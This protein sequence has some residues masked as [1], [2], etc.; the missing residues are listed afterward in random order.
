MSDNPSTEDSW[1]KVWAFYQG[2][3]ASSGDT[4]FTLTY[5][6]ASAT[7]PAATATDVLTTASALTAYGYTE[8]QADSIPVAINAL[9]ADALALRKVLV[10]VID[11]LVA[12]GA[13]TS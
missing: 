3:L 2:F 12:I 1:E 8:A 6:T 4:A 5:D 7:V 11:V 13:A 9:I 10:A